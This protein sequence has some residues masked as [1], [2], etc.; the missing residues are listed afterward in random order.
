MPTHLM[1]R[2]SPKGHEFF[3]E[4]RWC[5]QRGLAYLAKNPCKQ[6]PDNENNALA[7]IAGV[8]QKTQGRECK[9]PWWA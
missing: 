2:V 5:G 9:M 3:G 1:D 4:C 8:E 7:A 6:A